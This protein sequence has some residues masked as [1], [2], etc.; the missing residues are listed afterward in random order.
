M[1]NITDEMLIE[2]VAR[3]NIM[4]DLGNQ[5]YYDQLGK[6]NVKAKKRK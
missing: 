6:D 2:F 3:R 1:A 4:L 5:F